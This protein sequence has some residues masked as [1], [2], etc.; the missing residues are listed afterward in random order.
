MIILQQIC[1][2]LTFPFACNFSYEPK[3]KATQTLTL[4]YD[5]GKHLYFVITGTS[6]SL[7]HLEND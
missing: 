3:L 5:P 2:N 1:Q 6:T 4:S 7:L